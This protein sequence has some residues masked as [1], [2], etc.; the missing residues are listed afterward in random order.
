MTAAGVTGVRWADSR[1]RWAG[2]LSASDTDGAPRAASRRSESLLRLATT[3]ASA[4][5][6]RVGDV[7]EVYLR[8][9]GPSGALVYGAH[10]HPGRLITALRTLGRPSQEALLTTIAAGVP[11]TRQAVKA[12][13]AGSLSLFQAVDLTGA[14][15]VTLC[16]PLG[17][18][19]AARHAADAVERLGGRISGWGVESPASAHG[20]P[21]VRCYT[22]LDPA[23]PSPPE[24]LADLVDGATGR[25][26]E[27]VQD[28]RRWSGA[29]PVVVNLE[30]IGSASPAVKIEFPHV[31]WSDLPTP[32]D[33]EMLRWRAA[34]T[35]L[36][37]RL[38]TDRLS[39]LGVRY[40]PEGREWCGYVSVLDHAEEGRP[41]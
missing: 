13:E 10:S 8:S 12:D 3:L 18:A 2:P 24:K 9:R 20:S 4:I 15:L 30:L 21:R 5:D 36:A 14:D 40:R 17:C 37:E 6:A 34:L 28:W 19:T 7:V 41:R 38:T 27:T 31:S 16:G 29:D 23:G 35:G 25:G 1:R 26:D 11:T 32:A 33:H 22:M 39:H